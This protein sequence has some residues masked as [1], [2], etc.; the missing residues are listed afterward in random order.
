MTSRQELKIRNLAAPISHYTD[1]VRFGDLLLV[2]GLIAV[3]G[4]LKL[5][6]V[7]DVVEQ[8]RQVFRNMKLVLD[9]VDASFS[10]VLKVTVYLTD[11]NDRTVINPVRQEVFGSARPA[12]TLIEVSKLAL[13]EAKVEIEAIVGLKSQI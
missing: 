8:T 1:A 2:S 12:S 10:D 6:G 3:D 4:D 5:V 9:E 7:G 13:P 11:I